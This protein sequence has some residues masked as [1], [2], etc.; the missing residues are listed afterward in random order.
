MSDLERLGERLDAIAPRTM[1]E[2]AIPGAA[3][4]VV[5][6]DDE[7]IRCF[8][9]SDA[10]S[11]A[12]VNEDTLF[13]VGSVSKTLTATLLRPLVDAD[14]LDLDAPVRA[15]LPELRLADPRASEGVTC[16]HLLAHVAGFEGDIFIDNGDGADALARFVTALDAAPQ[17]APFDWSYSYCNAGYSLLGRVVEVL[18]GDAF[19]DVARSEVLEPLGMRRTRFAWEARAPNTASGHVLRDGVP[20]AVRPWRLSRSITPAGGVVSTARD[21]LAYARFHLGEQ[22]ASVLP[23]ESLEAMRL[24]LYDAAKSPKAFGWTIAR[25]GGSLVVSH[26]GSTVSHIAELALVPERRVAF[27]V[28]TNSDRGGAL[29]RAVS[30]LV[31]VE[32]LGAAA[33]APPPAFTPSIADAGEYAG[34]YRA[35]I[36]DVTVGTDADGVWL[37]AVRVGGMDAHQSPRPAPLPRMRLDFVAADRAVIRNGPLEEQPAWFARDPAGRVRWVRFYGRLTPRVRE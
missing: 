37:D 17:L 27:A 24:P 1:R 5:D 31:L 3:V 36:Y 33:P 9:A 15:H 19:E 2:H 20:R 29:V 28:L 23:R 14:R 11:G 21:L 32:H 13:Q 10:E 12:P 35:A 4:F 18:R 16:R 25:T 7:L 6:G 34:R 26:G 8:G 22:G 30:R